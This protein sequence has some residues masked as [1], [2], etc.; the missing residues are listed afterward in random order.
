MKLNFEN[1]YYKK[2]AL[3]HSKEYNYE[4]NNTVE[5]AFLLVLKDIKKED[6][7]NLIILIQET[8]IKKYNLKLTEDEAYEITQK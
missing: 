6:L 7:S 1:D 2:E 5:D 8:F 3:E 4:N